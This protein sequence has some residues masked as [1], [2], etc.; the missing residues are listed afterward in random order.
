MSRMMFPLKRILLLFSLGLLGACAPDSVES[1]A[2]TSTVP[3]QLVLGST[4][5]ISLGG[6][7]D[8][9]E[10]SFSAVSAGAFV[11][12]DRFVILDAQGHELKIYSTSGEHL[13][14]FSRRGEGPGE[15]GRLPELLAT[16]DG[17]IRI[18]DGLQQRLTVFDDEGRYVSSVRPMEEGEIRFVQLAGALSDNRVIWKQPNQS[19][20]AD[21]APTGAYRDTIFQVLR[22]ADG[23]SDTLAW[24]L[25]SEAF[26]ADANGQRL[27][28]PVP[29]GREGFAVVGGDRL[30][31]GVSDEPLLR[32][33]NPDASDGPTFR[34]E[35]VG[36]DP[37]SS[38]E[39]DS[40]RME[41]AAP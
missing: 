31:Y 23:S 24:T 4:S 7:D 29:L 10:Y 14:T 34:W 13:Q 36:R 15:L 3:T 9:P 32:S 8:R 17:T 18:W 28:T 21:N 38:R 40:L 33:K 6:L 2:E 5:R 20:G 22:S 16:A 39:I 37:V 19:R 26:R 35:D 25:A 30:I 11:G 41:M 27:S 1:T 12:P